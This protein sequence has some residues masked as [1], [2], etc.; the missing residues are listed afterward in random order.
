MRRTGLVV[1]GFGL[2][3]LAQVASAQWTAARRLTWN[4][5]ESKYPDIAVDASGNLHVVWDD[6]TPGNWEIFYK[7]STDGGVTWSWNKRLSW[8]SGGSSN[9]D[10]AVDASGNLHVVW[11]DSSPGNWEIFYKRSTDGGATWSTVRRISWNS[12]PSVGPV[13]AV[14][15]AANLHVVWYDESLSSGFPEIFYK[16]STD[17]GATWSASKRLTW[18]SG[19]SYDPDIAVDSA[20]NPH[21]VWYDYTPGAPE[22]YFKRSVD[23]GATWSTMKRL[24]WTSGGSNSPAITVDGP[25]KLHVVWE[26]YTPGNYDIYY[27]SSKDGGLTW[28]PNKILSWTSGGSEDPA[29]GVDSSGN[30]HVTWHDDTLGNDEIFYRRS[31]DGGVTWAPNKRLTWTSGESYNSAIAIDS[32]A[33]LHVVWQDNTPGNAEIYYKKFIK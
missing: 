17:G 26:D 1:A 18:T 2:F 5:G 13:I 33:N 32:S 20:G 30:L 22:I 19:P 25:G 23:G 7:R 10:I 29:I 21:V 6:F 28:T 11:C 16:K 27:K 8:N 9:P 24:T 4:L 31:A 12:G 14:D 15:S 3:L